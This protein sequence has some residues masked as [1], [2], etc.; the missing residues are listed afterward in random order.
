M[1]RTSAVEPVLCSH[2][3][4][5]AE[6]SVS[7]M[8][9]AI[10]RWLGW[11]AV[12]YFAAGQVYVWVVFLTITPG[13][14]R[15]VPEIALPAVLEIILALLIA[16]YV[17]LRIKSLV[18][19]ILAT[20]NAIVLLVLNF[21]T[22][23]ASIGTTANWAPK[24][25]RLD[26]LAVTLGTLTTAGAPGI[27]PHSELARGLVTTQLV[28]DILAAIVLFGLF[29]GRLARERGAGGLAPQPAGQRQE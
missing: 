8:K 11:L 26:G 28:V 12:A 6:A 9:W 24:L 10:P 27:T 2:D 16:S 17:I 3:A 13:T 1:A 22:W 25:T 23:Y 7:R 21:S 19:V 5:G 18:W 4:S 14:S 29:V 15:T 20:T